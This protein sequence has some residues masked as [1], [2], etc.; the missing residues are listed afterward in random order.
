MRRGRIEVH[1]EPEEV[2]RAALRRLLAAS[3]KPSD[4]RSLVLSGGSTPLELYRRLAALG[5]SGALDTGGLELYWGD[6]RTVPPDHPESNYGAA[7]AAWAGFA[8]IAAE[9]VHRLRGELDPDAAARD[10]R[11]LLARRFPGVSAPPFGAVILGLGEDGHTASLFPG[12]P[13]V[14]SA[15]WVEATG[16]PAGGRRLTL[17]PA[18]LASA[19]LVLFLVTGA[20]KSAAAAATLRGPWRPERWPAQAVMSVN[21]RVHWLLDRAAAAGLEGADSSSTPASRGFQG[22]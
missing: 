12:S 18:A 9:R 1:E 7:R 11:R 4:R 6:E 21:R 8:P 13:A 10:Y 19:G 3:S 22:S 17:T 14:S 15:R 2:A 5:R 16:H 20:A